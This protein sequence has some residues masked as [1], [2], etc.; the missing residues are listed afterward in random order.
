MLKAEF[1]QD[2]RRK[3]KTYKVYF[4]QRN[5]F[6]INISAENEEDARQKAP[7]AVGYGLEIWNKNVFW[8]ADKIEERE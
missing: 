2:Q 7:Q 5:A 1:Y 8:E 3:M 4:S 6:F